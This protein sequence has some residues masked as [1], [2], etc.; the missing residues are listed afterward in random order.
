[1]VGTAGNLSV[2]AGELVAVTATGA[3]FDTM[4]AAEVT[5]V[6]RSGQ[7]VAG[8][9]AP[10]SELDLH[11]GVYRHYRTAAIVHTHPPVGTALSCVLGDPG[12]LPVVH[13][14]LLA[15]GG[16]VRVARYATF[17]TPELADA[18]V[19]ALDGRGGA[20]MANHGAITHADSLDRAV[21]LSVLLEWVCTIYWRAAAV[22]TPR[23]LDAEEQAAAVAAF[24]A[25]RYGRTHPVE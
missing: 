12:E 11:L 10:T 9:L 19:V 21:E 14:Q 6:D 20:L 1:M 2:R 24:T 16:P 8:A 22:G 25:R 5:V 4:T 7:V 3:R 15:L 17:G 18:V 13:Y 23:V